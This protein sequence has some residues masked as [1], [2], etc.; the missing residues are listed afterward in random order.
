MKLDTKNVGLC[1]EDNRL[2]LDTK[3]HSV[4]ETSGGAAHVREDFVEDILSLL[5]SF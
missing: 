5:A 1:G 2:S 4:G 3:R